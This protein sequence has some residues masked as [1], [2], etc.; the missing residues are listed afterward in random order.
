M[1]RQWLSS[2]FGVGRASEK[3]SKADFAK[4]GLKHAR[5]ATKKGDPIRASRNFTHAV[6]DH[7][8][9][10]VLAFDESGGLVHLQSVDLTSLLQETLGA[11]DLLHKEIATGKVSKATAGNAYQLLTLSHV[12]MLFNDRQLA[13]RFCNLAEHDSVRNLSSPFWDEY[14]SSIRHFLTN[15]PYDLNYNRKLKD[16]ERYWIIYPKLVEAMTN[17]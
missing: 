11:Y 7:L 2:I 8:S 3:P 17:G 6:L 5:R 4:L 12:A 16:L 15:R 14:T 9:H 1:F 13:T 10:A